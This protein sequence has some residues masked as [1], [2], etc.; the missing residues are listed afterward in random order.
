MWKSLID[1][2][3]NNSDY[4]KLALK[5][6]LIKI[7]MEKSNAIPKYMNKFTQC[8]DKLGSVYVIVVEDDLASIALLGLPNSYHNY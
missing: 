3:Q 8:E 2:L 1:L 5:E 4:S 6:K 7:K